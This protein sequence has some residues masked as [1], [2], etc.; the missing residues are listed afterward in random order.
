M[1]LL[2]LLEG[3]NDPPEYD[4]PSGESFVDE[5]YNDEKLLF[6]YDGHDKESGLFV[7]RHVE[8]GKR[9]VGHTDYID[10]DMYQ[11]DTYTEWDRDEDGSYSY[12]VVD[13][14]NASLTPDSMRLQATIAFNEGD[15][16]VDFDEWETGIAI[17]EFGNVFLRGLYLNDK[18]TYESLI[19]LIRKINLSE[20]K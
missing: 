13:K 10:Y 7:V 3:W 17:I 6:N 11:A 8:S 19:N 1:K 2:D 20:K 4:D 12:E 14:D 9:Y 5:D 18:K 15:M 16:G